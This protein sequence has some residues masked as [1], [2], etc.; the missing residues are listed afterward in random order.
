MKDFM[1]Y[2]YNKIT[3][4]GIVSLFHYRKFKIHV[5]ILKAIKSPGFSIY[6]T[7]FFF[8]LASNMHYKKVRHVGSTNL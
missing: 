3:R 4:G 6:L 8:S 7:I 1:S 5:N 2:F